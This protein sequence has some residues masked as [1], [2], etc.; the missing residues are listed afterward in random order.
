MT[1]QPSA[2]RALAVASP[3]PRLDPVTIAIL[4]SSWR[5]TASM[6][7]E[8]YARHSPCKVSWWRTLVQS[9]EREE[10]YEVAGTFGQQQHRRSSRNGY[11]IASRRRHRRPRPAAAVLGAYRNEPSRHD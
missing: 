1:Q 3:R 2:A 4:F 8:R 11:R 7:T 9:V 6:I 10:P 5:F